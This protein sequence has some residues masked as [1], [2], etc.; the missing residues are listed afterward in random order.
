M[1]LIVIFR[2]ELGG[3]RRWVRISGSGLRIRVIF[4]F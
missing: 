2:K 1:V 4:E 3:D